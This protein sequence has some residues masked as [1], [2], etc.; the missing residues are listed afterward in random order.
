MW[1]Q[2]KVILQ[3]LGTIATKRE[4]NRHR[5]LARHLRKRGFMLPVQVA[6]LKNVLWHRWQNFQ[7]ATWSLSRCY[8]YIYIYVP[9]KKVLPWYLLGVVV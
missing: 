7:F 9:P 1:S 4:G 5:D 8:I 6:W 3:D 2:E